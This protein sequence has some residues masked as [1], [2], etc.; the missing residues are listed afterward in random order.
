MY[1]HSNVCKNFCNIT[2]K[3]SE[4]AKETDRPKSFIEDTDL[5]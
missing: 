3:L 4:I 5:F 1:K 2:A